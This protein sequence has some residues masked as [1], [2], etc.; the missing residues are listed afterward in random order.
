M[1][2]AKEKSKKGKDD[3]L[4]RKILLLTRALKRDF[5]ILQQLS[6]GELLKLSP[7]CET[8]DELIAYLRRYRRLWLECEGLIFRPG[9]YFNE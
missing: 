8:I 5:P 2:E 9:P 6:P 4:R 1:A 3:G 7:S